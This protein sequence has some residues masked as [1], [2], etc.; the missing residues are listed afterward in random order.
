MEMAWLQVEIIPML[1]VGR[2]S[3]AEDGHTL[4]DIEPQLVDKTPMR[5]ENPQ[6]LV[7]H[8]HTL[9]DITQVQVEPILMLKDFIN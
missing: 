8:T 5:R 9:K 4:K 2:P 3:P 7:D 1:K 6:E